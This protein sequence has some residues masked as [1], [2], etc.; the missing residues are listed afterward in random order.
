MRIGY[1]RNQ[2]VELMENQ[3]N[4]ILKNG[5]DKVV[6]D[7]TGER[8]S[9]LLEKLKPGDVLN[10]SSLDRFSRDIQKT[11]KVLEELSNKGVELYVGGEPFKLSDTLFI[12]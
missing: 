4:V 5:I 2:D 6:L 1:V 10:I 8:L 11:V 3:L 12:K 7:R 9:E